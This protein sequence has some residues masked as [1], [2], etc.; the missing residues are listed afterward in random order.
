MNCFVY[1]TILKGMH[2]NESL[3]DSPCLG[4]AC[5]Q[6]DLFDLGDYPGMI[7]GD[8]LVYGE[9]YEIDDEILAILD[10][11]E[12]FFPGRAKDSLYLRSEITN[13]MLKD[14]QKL[15][16]WAYFYNRDLSKAQRI[17]HGDYRRHRAEAESDRVHRIRLEHEL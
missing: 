8:G 10:Q 11:I 6:G 7:Q 9:V 1:G 5:T 3:L 2:R 12:G 13:T 15:Q 16:A 17:Q 14:G 4:L